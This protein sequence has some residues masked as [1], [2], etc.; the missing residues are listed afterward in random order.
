MSEI[1]HTCPIKNNDP[2]AVVLNTIAAEM[3]NIK[4]PSSDSWIETAYGLFDSYDDSDQE[5]AELLLGAQDFSSE[6]INKARKCAQHI[7]WGECDFA[8]LD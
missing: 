1:C 2:D 7:L 5:T 8:N 6:K 4:E 3:V